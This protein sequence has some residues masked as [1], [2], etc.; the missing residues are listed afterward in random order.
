LPG[1]QANQITRIPVQNRFS[2]KQTNTVAGQIVSDSDYSAFR[3]AQSPQHSET[4]VAL[5][6]DAA[7]EHAQTTLPLGTVSALKNLQAPQ[8]IQIRMTTSTGDR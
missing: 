3:S 2:A 8:I 4:K 7:V 1:D 5:I 6:T